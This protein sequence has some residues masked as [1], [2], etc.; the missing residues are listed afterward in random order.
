MRLTKLAIAASVLSALLLVCGALPPA[1]AAA[2]PD[3]WWGPDLTVTWTRS[4]TLAALALASARAQC[5]VRSEVGNSGNDY[6]PYSIGDHGT[7]YGPAQLHD[8][9][10]LREY[11]QWSGGASPF[12]PVRSV[13][14]VD[15][16]LQQGRGANW[17]AI[18]QGRC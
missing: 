14:F 3:P 10:L 1:L 18:R 8:G 7:S 15:A 13:E 9:G 2:P 17:T 4:D 16:A 11:E 6:D 12:N 5:I